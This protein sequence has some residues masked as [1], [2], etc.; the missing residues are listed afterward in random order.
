MMEGHFSSRPALTLLPST[1]VPPQGLGR[2]VRDESGRV[3]AIVEEAEADEAQRSIREVNG[4]V[5]C[6]DSRWLWKAV[7]DLRPGPSGELYLTDLVS[8]ASS[9]DALVLGI[10]SNEPWEVLGINNRIQLSQAESVLRQ[11]IRE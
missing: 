5:Y 1:L 9:S 7:E 3:T 2:I 8:F 10:A 4:G 6:F 11:R